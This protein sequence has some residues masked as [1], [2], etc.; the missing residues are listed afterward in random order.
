[1][2]I[3]TTSW[4]ELYHFTIFLRQLLIPFTV[5]METTVFGAGLGMCVLVVVFFLYMNRKWCFSNT[6]GNFPCC[7]EKSLSTK[8]IHSFSEYILKIIWMRHAMVPKWIFYEEELI[9]RGRAFDWSLFRVTREGRK[10]TGNMIL[11][12]LKFVSDSGS[13]SAMILILFSCKKTIKTHYVDDSLLFLVIFMNIL[14]ELHR[15]SEKM[16]T[17]TSF[18]TYLHLHSWKVVPELSHGISTESII[19]IL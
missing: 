8:T 9:A 2:K 17:Q 16:L 18:Q 1:M 13:T 4:K 15:F 14:E 6:S 7:D 5:S 11:S 19:S 12:S 3:Y 10:E